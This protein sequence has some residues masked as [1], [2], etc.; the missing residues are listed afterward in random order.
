MP[1]NC[2]FAVVI[3]TH[4]RPAP[5]RYTVHRKPKAAARAASQAPRRI[6]DLRTCT[7][8][9]LHDARQWPLDGFR[10]AIDRGDYE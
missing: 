7:V 5:F 3:S 4:R 2:R 1:T 10:A 8:I 6:R 9:S